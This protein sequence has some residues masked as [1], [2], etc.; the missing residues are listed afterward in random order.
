MA[1][2]VREALEQSKSLQSV[3]DTPD[4]DVQLILAQV[5]GEDR[6]YLFAHPDAILQPLQQYEFH[7]LLNR[8]Q[9][10]E[11]LAYILGVKE[12]WSIEF[13]VSPVVL[14]PRPETELLVDLALELLPEQPI[15]M[16]DLGTGSGAIAAALASERPDWNIL[17]SDISITTL[18]LAS[19]NISRIFAGKS[20]IQLVLA[21]WC[22][23]FQ[24]PCFDL[25]IS[26]PPY[27]SPSDPL[28]R[29][30]PLV[31]EP[32]SALVSA[33]DGLRDINK[34]IEDA[35][36]CLKPGGWLI[37][38]HGSDQMEKVCANLTDAGYRSIQSKKDLGN[39]SRAVIAQ[40]PT[41]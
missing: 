18:L 28:L 16:V 6:S 2:T 7:K 41:A 1:I 10:G 40:I 8:C 26:N 33:L 23:P 3:S 35:R 38:E 24:Q 31:Y 27:I 12:F 20:N 32:A 4:L 5:V 39:H 13:D 30:T 25:M 36:V 15:D 17:A 21:D 14:I 19:A 34:I 11:P 29:R 22:Q 9:K 37:L